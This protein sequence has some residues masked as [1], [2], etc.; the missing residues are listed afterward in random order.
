MT[1]FKTKFLKIKMQKKL[2]KGSKMDK[3][4]RNYTSSPITLGHI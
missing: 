2:F 1:L 4:H 3:T